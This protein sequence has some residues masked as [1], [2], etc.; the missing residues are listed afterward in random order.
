L[1]V[2]NQPYFFPNIFGG[3]NRNMVPQAQ[4]PVFMPSNF[5]PHMQSNVQVQAPA[6]VAT[7]QV[8]RG[9]A[10]DE[11][12]APSV[13]SMPAPEHFGIQNGT[14]A[15]SVTPSIQQVDWA[16]V[17]SRLRS[18][19]S[20][21]FQSDKTSTGHRVLC[22]IPGKLPGSLQRFE[23]HDESEAQAVQMLLEKLNE[24]QSGK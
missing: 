3:Q 5:Q 12:K 19:G 24:W 10:P 11:V 8:I 18:A 17:H 7:K 14:V 16:M 6:P 1:P 21:T 22:M 2:A 20:V 15:K 13:I 23:S 4:P 9:Q